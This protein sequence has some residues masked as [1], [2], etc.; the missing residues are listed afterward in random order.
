MGGLGQQA[1]E[2]SPT[3]S[4]A[5]R[6]NGENLYI[7]GNRPTENLYLIDGLIVNDYADASPGSGLNVNLG[8]DAVREFAVLTYGFS[9]Q[10]GMTSGGVVNAAFK[11]G[12]NQIHGTG[13]G[14]FRNSAL[15]ARNYYDLPSGVPPFHRNQY[16][17]SV[18]GPIRKDKTF[19]FSSFEGLNQALSL[20]ENSLTLSNEARM[21]QVPNPNGSDNITSLSLPAFNPSLRSSLSQMERITATALPFTFFRAHRLGAN[22]TQWVKSTIL[23][24][25]RPICPEATNG[26][27][28]RCWRQIPTIRS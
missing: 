23:S 5:A 6:G 3:N 17:A 20:S 28:L 2:G 14:F 25:S 27:S 21:G 8:V 1:T 15:D 9:A 7:N 22:T 19:F 4:R 12:T 13:F 16:G 11:S 18:G 26:I 24:P 10:Y